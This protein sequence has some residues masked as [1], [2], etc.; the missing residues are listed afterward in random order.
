[1]LIAHPHKHFYIHTGEL[2]RSGFVERRRAQFAGGAAAVI[3]FGYRA[4]YAP[5]VEFGTSRS[6][7][8]PFLGPALRKERPNILRTIASAV[9]S[10]IRRAV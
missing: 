1:M 3:T 4:K 2:L 7:A 5:F 10:A 8:F 6:R 9:Q